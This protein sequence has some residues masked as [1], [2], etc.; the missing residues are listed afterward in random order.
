MH[1]HAVSTGHVA[2]DGKGVVREDNVVI[3][4]DIT[5]TTRAG[6][7]DAVD[8]Q[9]EAVY[10]FKRIRN[11]GSGALKAMYDAYLHGSGAHKQQAAALFGS[12]PELSP[13]TVGKDPHYLVRT[14]PFEARHCNPCQP[15]LTRL[16]D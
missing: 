7:F 16:H 12:L 6:L 11:Q 5:D 4:A 2:T 15:F 3:L 13:S 8:R 14:A 9:L 10:E 1:S